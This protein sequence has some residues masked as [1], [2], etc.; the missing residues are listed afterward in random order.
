MGSYSSTEATTQENSKVE[1]V[2]VSTTEGCWDQNEV[3]DL[4]S[5]VTE[6][7]T[8]AHLINEKLVIRVIKILEIDSKDGF[9]SHRSITLELKK[10]LKP[11][12]ETLKE[13]LDALRHLE[14]KG[15]LIRRKRSYKLVR[16]VE[17]FK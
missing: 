8:N 3:K 7:M 13:L 17:F 12:P 15:K 10:R 4:A 6:T 1:D 5:I 14:K 16:V 2:P 11:N 9:V